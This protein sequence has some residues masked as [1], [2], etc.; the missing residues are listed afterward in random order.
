MAELEHHIFVI[1]NE[2]MDLCKYHHRYKTA[3]EKLLGNFVMVH[4]ADHI[5]THL[6]LNVT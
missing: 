4:H 3:N 2:I 5:W 1:P 6:D